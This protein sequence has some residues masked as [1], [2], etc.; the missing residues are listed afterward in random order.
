MAMSLA[1]AA[2]ATASGGTDSG[3][4]T[5]NESN[6]I[7][8]NLSNGIHG[9]DSIDSD[10]VLII[11]P[12]PP[13]TSPESANE[14]QSHENDDS[15]SEMAVTTREAEF[16]IDQGNNFQDLDGDD[17]VTEMDR[18]ID[19][20]ELVDSRPIPSSGNFF[21]VCNG[22]DTRRRLVLKNMCCVR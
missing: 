20:D 11:V 22:R 15:E 4:E 3:V 13:P 1:A 2:A 9:F 16:H 6:D 14:N 5:G 7:D 17:C 19:E 12:P 18:D 21:T 8:V 10:G